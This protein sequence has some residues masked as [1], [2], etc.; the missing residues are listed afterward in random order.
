M[1]P[2][3][4]IDSW[5]YKKDRDPS[6]LRLPVKT[7][8]Y[9]RCPAIAPLGV[10][11]DEATQKRIAIS[12]NQVSKNLEVLKKH[13][14]EFAQKILQTIAKLDVERQKEYASHEEQSVDARLYDDFFEAADKQAMRLVRAA[15]AD[16]LS[17]LSGKMS[18]ARL[19]EMLPLYK[20]RNYPA[21]LTFEERQAWEEHIADALL[22]GGEQSRAARYFARLQ[23]LAAHDGLTSEQG[24]LLEEL[25][26]YG[27]SILPADLTDPDDPGM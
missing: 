15:S 2:E 12:L 14:H 6:D 27:E 1:T 3:Q 23:E 19:Q 24:Y 20:A 17:D 18:S 9:N 22:S 26:L 4:L 10:I 8:K 7:L 5:R 21:A 11:K 25:R 13:Q 16:E